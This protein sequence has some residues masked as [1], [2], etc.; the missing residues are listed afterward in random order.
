MIG[1]GMWKYEYTSV[2]DAAAAVHDIDRRV[3]EEGVR[4]DYIEVL[5]EFAGGESERC[6]FKE[7]ERVFS[8]L[9]RF[10]QVL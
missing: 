10:E 6:A 3:R 4:L 2:E 9:R 7:K 5:V 8:W 1:V